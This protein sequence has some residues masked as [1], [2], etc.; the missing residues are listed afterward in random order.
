[1][2]HENK[3]CGFR[4]K[5]WRKNMDNAKVQWSGQI[6]TEKKKLVKRKQK[7]ISASTGCK[8]VSP[9]MASQEVVLRLLC[10]NDNNIDSVH[11]YSSDW[12]T[13]KTEVS[14]DAELNCS[15]ELSISLPKESFLLTSFFYFLDVNFSAP[16]HFCFDHIF[17]SMFKPKTTFFIIVDHFFFFLSKILFIWPHIFNFTVYFSKYQ[18]SHFFFLGLFLSAM[19]RHKHVT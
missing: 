18:V 14:Q 15:S 17:S 9:Y 13:K 19:K 5:N 3:K 11:W 10:D 12:R 2:V 6:N 7:L 16:Q 1:M 8:R 4:F